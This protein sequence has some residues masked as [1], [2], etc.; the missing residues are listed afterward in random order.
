MRTSEVAAAAD[1]NV[2]TLRYYER[3]GLLPEPA[4]RGA[5]YRDYDDGAIR[6]VRFIKRAQELGFS[7]D[8]IR[9]LL[10]LRERR[11]SAAHVRQVAVVKIAAA[12]A[13]RGAQSTLVDACECSS[14]PR[15]CPIIE[16]LD[17]EPRPSDARVDDV[18]TGDRS[19]LA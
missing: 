1:V 13:M 3:R 17:D 18:L 11:G 15:E 5:R 4:R 8:E 9:E 12:A 16:A 10:E 2:Q 14:A 7:L 19:W 6:R